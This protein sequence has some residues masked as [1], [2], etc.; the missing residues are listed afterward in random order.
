MDRADAPRSL[1]HRRSFLKAAVGC[2]AAGALAPALGAVGQ[3]EAAVSTTASDGLRPTPAPAAGLTG[4]AR[5]RAVRAEFGLPAD[6]IHMNTGTTGSQPLFALHNLGAYNQAKLRDPRDWQANLAAAHPDLCPLQDGSL[7]PARQ[8]RVAGAYG[9][10]ADEIV[11]SYN[12]TDALAMVFAGT[13]WRAGDRIV[14]TTFE[15]PALSGPAAWARDAHGV[16]VVLV[17]IPSR[18]GPDV[19][20]DEVVSWFE[21]ALAAPRPAGS[22]QYLA[23]SEI[24]YR[25]G[26]R[27]PVA[28]LSAMARRHDAFVIVDAAHCWGMAPMDCHASGADVIAGAGHK[29]LCGGPGTG[30]LYMRTTGADRHPLPPCAPAGFASYGNVFTAPS[31]HDGNRSWVPARAMQGRGELNTPALLAMTDTLDF[32]TKVGLEAIY[33]RGVGLGRRLKDL[34]LERWGAR[35]LWVDPGAAEFATALTSFNPFAGSDDAA[36]FEQHGAA[37]KKVLAGLAAESPK[38]YIR[39]A[40]WRSEAAAPA[41]DRIGLRVSTHGVYN[42]EDQVQHVFRRI[43]AQVDAAGLPQWG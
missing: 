28:A 39:T 9:A 33:E 14:T 19:T 24:F 12:T 40:T 42:D 38:I 13:P 21:P 11:L 5:W 16:D 29:W 22:R 2:A 43:C 25:N 7:L 10:D 20:V 8:A 34:V 4:E 32:F 17:S 15:H 23:L 35:A 31:P 41:D 1:I 37:M 18:F 3:A 26:L 30:I 27:M 6:Y 36:N